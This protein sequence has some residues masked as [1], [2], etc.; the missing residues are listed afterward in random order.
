MNDQVVQ[1]P[2]QPEQ[3]GYDQPSELKRNE[4]NRDGQPASGNTEAKEDAEA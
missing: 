3:V 1:K 2:V 4:D